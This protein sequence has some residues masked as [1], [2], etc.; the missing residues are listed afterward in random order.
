MTIISSEFF[1]RDRRSGKTPLNYLLNPSQPLQA[2]QMIAFLP[3]G[4][5]GEARLKAA[6][7]SQFPNVRDKAAEF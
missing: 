6:A 7:A 2:A 5:Y 3:R 1:N 4:I